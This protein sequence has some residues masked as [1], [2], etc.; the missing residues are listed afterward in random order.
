MADITGAENGVLILLAA[1][2]KILSEAGALALGGLIAF[3][4]HRPVIQ[5]SLLLVGSLKK[6][7]LKQCLI[8]QWMLIRR[9]ID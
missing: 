9:L 5:I 3:S 4:K 8:A 7:E 6:R 1:Y 2:K